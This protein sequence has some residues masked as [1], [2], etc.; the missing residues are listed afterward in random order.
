MNPAMELQS[1]GSI[2]GTCD[3]DRT[4]SRTWFWCRRRASLSDRSCNAWISRAI[5]QRPRGEISFDTDQAIR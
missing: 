1:Q 2:L 3:A 5:P 4:G